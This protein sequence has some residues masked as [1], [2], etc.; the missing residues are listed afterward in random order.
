M[1]DEHE[2]AGECRHP[3]DLI[4]DVTSRAYGQP[5]NPNE[6][7][8]LD[9]ILTVQSRTMDVRMRC[10]HCNA[11]MKFCGATKRAIAEGTGLAESVIE[12]AG[13]SL[14]EDGFTLRLPFGPVDAV[15]SMSDGRAF[16]F[17]FMAE[18][19]E[20]LNAGRTVQ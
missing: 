6:P 13:P 5:I 10:R 7:P 9:N 18:Y 11:P 14:S 17:P 8:S 15:T 16:G 4:L 20:K 12:Q 2:A 3:G 19:L 1:S